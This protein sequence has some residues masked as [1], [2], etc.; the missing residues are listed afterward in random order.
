VPREAIEHRPLRS[1]AQ[2]Q[3]AYADAFDV[4]A[5]APSEAALHVGYELGRRAV[6]LGVSV[7]ELAR[8]HHEALRAAL[9]S[10]MTREDDDVIARGADFLAECLSAFEMIRRGYAEAHE[11]ARLERRQAAVLRRLSSLLADT[12]LALD[13]ARS[14]AEMLRLVAETARELTGARYSSVTLHAPTAGEARL[15]VVSGERPG[16][17][18]DEVTADLTELGG[19]RIGALRVS[20]SESPGFSEVDEALLTQLAQMAA[21][22][23]ERTRLYR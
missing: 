17:D 1:T 16:E 22:A 20:G 5:A 18:G 21:A 8:I 2:L 23:F 9:A 7:P 13:R 6:E 12:S 4:Y 14:V 19:R 11:R 3:A 10:P 15:E